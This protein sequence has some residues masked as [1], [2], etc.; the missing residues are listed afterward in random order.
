MF[1]E[2]RRIDRRRFWLGDEIAPELSEIA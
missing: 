2:M 1:P